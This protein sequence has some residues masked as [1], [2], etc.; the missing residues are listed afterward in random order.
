MVS[1]LHG[2][3]K[4]SLLLEAPKVNISSIPKAA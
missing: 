3:G 2:L 1:A 4:V